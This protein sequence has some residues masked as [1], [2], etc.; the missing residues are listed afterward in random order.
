[1]IRDIAFALISAAIWFFGWLLMWWIAGPWIS[2]SEHPPRFGWARRHLRTAFVL[3]WPIGFGIVFSVAQFVWPQ[4]L[5]WA[6]I[7]GM[8][9][10]MAIANLIWARRHVPVSWE[11]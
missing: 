6:G 3:L 4:R 10:G 1:M 8:V 9:I 2:W 11:E 5:G 7:I